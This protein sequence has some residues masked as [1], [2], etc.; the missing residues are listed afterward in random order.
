MKAAVCYAF[1]Q[2]LVVEGLALDPSQAEEV[3][4]RLAATSVCHGDVH[5]IWGDSDQRMARL[6]RRAGRSPSDRHPAK[7]IWGHV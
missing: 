3:R 2:P 1:G 4:V 5:L 6:A 7:G